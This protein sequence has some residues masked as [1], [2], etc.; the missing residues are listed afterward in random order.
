M[1]EN[2]GTVLIKGSYVLTMNPTNE[3]IEDGAV[4]VRGDAIVEVG[5]AETIVA[6]H[7][8]AEVIDAGYAILMPGLVNTHTHAAMV[9]FRGLADDMVLS[10]WLNEKIWPAE[11][12]FVDR[13]FI[14]VMFPL[15]LAEMI[16]SGT[17]TFADVYFFEKD[18]AVI[19]ETVGIRAMLGEGVLDFPTPS[20]KGP[21]EGLR[22]TE[23]MLEAWK[24]HPTVHPAVCLHAPYTCSEDT[25]IVGK[26]LSDRFD[27]PCMIHI[28]ESRSEVEDMERKRGR[29]PV[30]YL[31][32]IGF[33]SE[34][35]VGAHC[36]WLDDEE[37][38][39]FKERRA[40]VAHN[41]ESNMKLS[42]G[43]APMTKFMGAGVK[44][45]L[46]TDGAASNN[47]LDMFGAMFT[48]SLL[49]KVHTGDPTALKAPEV[50]RAATLGGAE[51]LGMVDRI[52]SLE[53]GKR[54]DIISVSLESPRMTPMYDPFSHL[55]YCARGSDVTHA[56]VNG[57]LLLRDRRHLTLDLESVIGRARDLGERIRKEFN[58]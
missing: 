3:V 27:V 10:E 18:A 26:A 47:D 12:K 38:R 57:R 51:V 1:A 32:D 29:T 45:G 46:A 31:N 25:L 4:A 56:M 22:Y 19:S 9:G 52:G 7:R 24:D 40:G 42:S 13:Q 49:A 20:L 35:V 36:V 50:V 58:G 14:E 11:A 54:A 55:V 2:Q 34:R 37:I 21:A 33:L 39:I 43:I 23:E 28:S 41:P 44:T 53:T 6:N 15:A 5:N 30:R 8:D 17:T 16:A 48:A